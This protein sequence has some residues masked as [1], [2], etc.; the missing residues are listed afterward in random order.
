MNFNRARWGAG[1]RLD[2]ND[3]AHLFPRS[4]EIS[5]GKQVLSGP[6]SVIMLL[7]KDDFH[8]ALHKEI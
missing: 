7:H 2:R 4:V 3:A 6:I 1:R 8:V 5:D